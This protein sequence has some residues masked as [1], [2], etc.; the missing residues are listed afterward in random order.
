MK[1]KKF[2]EKVGRKREKENFKK[3]LVISKKVSNFVAQ[4]N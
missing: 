3:Y 4:Q 1:I 2:I